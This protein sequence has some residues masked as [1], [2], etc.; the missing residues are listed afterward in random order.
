MST[1]KTWFTKT[2]ARDT[3][4]AKTAELLNDGEISQEVKTMLDGLFAGKTVA[5]NTMV[6][7]EDGNIVMKRCSYFGVYLPI[8]AFGTVGKDDEG[9]SKYSYQSKEGA[10]ASRA[11]KTTLD[12]AIKEADEQLEVDEDVQSWKQSKAD[13]VTASEEKSEYDGE[14]DAIATYEDACESIA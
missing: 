1:E 5:T 12:K 4:T 11:T 2:L 7:D 6:R 9:K 10:A 3:L 8:E 13:A 14:H